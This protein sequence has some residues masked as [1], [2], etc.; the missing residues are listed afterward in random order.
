FLEDEISALEKKDLQFSDILVAQ[1]YSILGNREKAEEYFVS[2]A[3]PNNNWEFDFLIGQGA[4]TYKK[5]IDLSS[6]HEPELHLLENY[7]A[8]NSKLT[9]IVSMDEFFLRNYGTQLLTNIIALKKYHLHIHLVTRDMTSAVKTLV[10]TQNLFESIVKYTNKKSEI[11]SPTFTYESVNKDVENIKT[12]SA[13]AR[14]IHSYYF[15]NKFGKDI[16]ILDADMFLTDDL[17]S[18]IN[19]ISK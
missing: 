19:F 5:T 6:F 4:S 12:Y 17:S 14:Y 13:C 3:E 2:A 8:N 15:M 18:Y 9:M 10:D 7:E 11:I 1:Y 16:L